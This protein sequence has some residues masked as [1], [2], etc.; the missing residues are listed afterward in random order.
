MITQ[1]R[2]KELLH[3]NPD[4]GIFIRKVSRQGIRADG[5]AGYTRKDGYIQIK[6]D[7]KNYF[8]Q[9]LAWLDYYGYLPE[10]ELD[11][12]DRIRHHNWIDNLRKASQQCNLRNTGNRGDN[13]SSVKGVFFDKARQK[14]RA[15]IY[16]D[17]GGYH[18]G[19][20]TDFTEAVAHRLAAEQ[21]LNWS[22]CDSYSPAFQYMQKYIGGN[23][24]DHGKL[25]C[26]VI[27]YN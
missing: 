21:C 6:I 12:I 4:T 27:L 13:T 17:S 20:F 24:E 2:L 9:R 16:L 22:T 1:S 8:A 5:V 7:N 26:K 19:S 10:N 15:L 25:S 14:W 3:Y 11:H 18:L 23:F